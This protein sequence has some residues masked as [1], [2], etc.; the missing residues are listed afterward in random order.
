MA[1]KINEKTAGISLAG[2]QPRQVTAKPPVTEVLVDSQP[3]APSPLSTT[4]SPSRSPSKSFT[5]AG[6]FMS[7]ITGKDELSK[8][9]AEVQG[10]LNAATTLAESFEGADLVRALGTKQVRRSQWANRNPA[11][12][13]SPEFKALTE[14]IRN[15]GG[16]TQAIK[17]R[18]VTGVVDGQPEEFE[19]VFGHRRFQACVEA[20]L[21]VNAVIVDH[22]T[23]LE[24]FEAMERENRGRKNLSAW[25]QGMMY[26]DALKKGLYSSARKLEDALNLNHSDCARALQLAK[27]PE[28]LVRAFESPLDLQVRWA[29]PLTDAMQKDPDSL[30]AAAR[31]I[32]SDRNGLSPLEIFERLVGKSAQQANEVQEIM[33]LGKRVATF[34]TGSTGRAVI[35]FEAGSLKP[36]KQNQLVA[37]IGKFLAS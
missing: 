1:K 23:D 27:L 16:N 31:K 32:A 12:F 24:L 22:M 9:L 5:G 26:Q 13:L 30:L 17:V 34:K 10:R 6:I 8:E 28:A 7:A 3:T 20:G 37:M 15:A 25:E 19:I 14:E 29:K 4:P 21:K 18:R 2:F 33:V 35:E 36:G 11:E